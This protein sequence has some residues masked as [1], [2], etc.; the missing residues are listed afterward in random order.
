MIHNLPGDRNSHFFLYF[1]HGKFPY[2][3][4]VFKMAQNVFNIKG[5]AATHS[6][7]QNSR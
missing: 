6:E 7:P 3:F 2:E 5:E 1:A 4:K